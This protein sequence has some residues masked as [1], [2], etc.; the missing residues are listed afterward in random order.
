MPP[1]IDDS[2]CTGCGKC[3]ELCAEDVF[4][5]SRNGETPMVTY[6]EACFH[7]YCCVM[8]CPVKD[9]IHLRTPLTM[10]VPFG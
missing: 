3:F 1:E 5:G 7:C 2:K 6:P 10:M 9:A 4:F 8:E